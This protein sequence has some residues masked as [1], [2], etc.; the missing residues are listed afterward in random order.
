MRRRYLVLDQNVLR[1]PELSELIVTQPE[2]RFVLPDLSFLEMT[3]SEQWETTLQ[4]SLQQLATVPERV[5]VAYSVNE[6]LDRELRTLQSVV[7][8]MHHAEATK[9]VRNV[10][11]WVRTGVSNPSI[12]RIREDPEKHKKAVQLDHLDHKGNKL[13]L[14]RLIGST[15]RFIPEEIQKRMRGSVLTSEGRLDIVYDIARGLVP[16]VLASRGVDRN[17]SRAFL[18]QRPLLY[19]YLI[20]KV[21]YCADWIAKGGFESFR[22]EAVSN[23]ILDHQYVLTA[24]FFDGL[25]TRE[26]KVNHAY[27]D[28]Q[29]LMLR[30]VRETL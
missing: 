30:A 12:D 2:A 3:K 27:N 18:R 1:R 11:A 21:W 6:A 14:A 24:S 13:A 7:G 25:I 22:E 29:A 5:L 4:R 15:R 17:K 26:T 9:F 20:V 10:L 28:L 16:E 23:E 8:H 19:R